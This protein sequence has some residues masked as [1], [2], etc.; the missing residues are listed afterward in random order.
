M[1]IA[2]IGGGA[3]GLFLA[4]YLKRKFNKIDITIFDR[5]K[6]LGRKLLAT[7][8]GKCNFSNYKA[9]PD[10]YNNKEFILKLFEKCPKEDLINYFQ[11]LGL[12]FY[13]DEEGRMY[14]ITN[15]SQTILNLFL[16]DLKNSN[17]KVDT[18][19]NNIYQKLNKVYVNDIEFD[20]A[21]LASGSNAS[22]DLK[23]VDSTYNYLKNLDLKFNKL[24]P[25]LVGYKLKDNDIKILKGYRSKGIVKLYDN[26]YGEIMFKEDGI[27][28]IVVM[29]SSHYY[30][31]GIK[32][33]IDLLPNISKE[34]MIYNINLRMKKNNNL[35]YYLESV[36]H[37]QLIEYLKK[38]KFNQPEKIIDYLSNYNP[39]IID[40][41]SIK[42]AQVLKGGIDVSEID[43]NFNLLKY[44]HIFVVGELLDINGL[45]GGYNLMFAFMSALVAARK[46]G[47]IYENKDN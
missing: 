39:E 24:E 30:K 7:G 5:N 46:I 45:C 13:F 29:N 12:M 18:V 25:S 38:K 32:I 27:S 40:T 33:S 9:L 35:D 6:S 11:S 2:I 4:S 41:Y 44:N 3:S 1:K 8:N 47:D 36:F 34:E 16:E 14:P 22:I 17:I 28:G 26:E 23:K 20:Y 37:P 21:V 10:D 42:E 19:V 15:S 43:S 31:K